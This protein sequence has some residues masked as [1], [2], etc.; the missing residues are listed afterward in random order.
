MPIM[1]FD[2]NTDDVDD[3]IN[4]RSADKT[5]TTTTIG[6]IPFIRIPIQPNQ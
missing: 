1:L 5:T 3:D 2:S 6:N 4:L